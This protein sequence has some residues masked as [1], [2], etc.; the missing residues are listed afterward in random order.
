MERFFILH[1]GKKKR[2]VFRMAKDNPL[3]LLVE[4]ND[5]HAQLVTL[6]MRD[7]GIEHKLIR[8][9]DGVQAMNFLYM[10]GEFSP[11]TAERPDLILL[12]LRLPKMDGLEVLKAVKTDDMLRGI[13]VVV[14][15]TSDAEKDIIMAY[16]FHANSY[17]VKPMH[18]D[19]LS[20]MLQETGFY[21]LACNKSVF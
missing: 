5:G 18:Y 2:G 19:E 6:G 21:W 7:C 14:L 20:S 12:D 11:E 10:R 8:V 16:E 9:C 17:L 1:L 3:V 13:P 15:T 4:D